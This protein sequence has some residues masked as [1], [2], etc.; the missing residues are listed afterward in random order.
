MKKSIKFLLRKLF[1][2]GLRYVLNDKW[3]AKIRYWIELEKWPN[4]ENPQKFTEKIQ[5]IKLH[6]HTKVRRLA[7]NRQAVRSYISQKIGSEHLVPLIGVYDELT[8]K[9]W[10]ELPQQFVL[11]ANHGSGMVKIVRDKREGQFEVIQEETQRW[12]ETDYYK[13]GREWAYK[14]LPR[15]ILAEEL[16][17]DDDRNIPKDYKFFCYHGKVKVIQVDSG[18]FGNHRQTLFDRSFNRIDGMLISPPEPNKISKPEGL[19]AAIEVAE[20]LASDFSFIRVDLY[21]MKE[22]I[23]FG[24]LTNYPL[25]GFIPFK[26]ESLEVK[27][28]SFLNLDDKTN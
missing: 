5:Y 13:L 14:G 19:K 12:K 9:I 28:G 23:Y 8:R 26:P 10:S 11:K 22:K 2:G 16:L 1:W 25:S 24:E 4:L 18:R 15:T 7:A 21:I 27:M 3:H 6:E 20:K 17:L